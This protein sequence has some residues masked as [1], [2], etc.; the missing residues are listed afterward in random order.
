MQSFNNEAMLIKL[1]SVLGSRNT[2]TRLCPPKARGLPRKTNKQT[3]SK[4]S[5]ETLSQRYVEE[6][7]F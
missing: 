7:L 4:K 5:G 3:G 2:A 1:F 6:D